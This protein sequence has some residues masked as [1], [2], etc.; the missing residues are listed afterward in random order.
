MNRPIRILFWVIAVIGVLIVFG[1]VLPSLVS[2]LLAILLLFAIADLSAR[3]YRN[4]VRTFNSAVRAVCQHEGAIA[5]VALAFSRSG[6]LSG[7]CYEYARR[8]MTGEDPVEAAGRARVP[9]QL[10]TAVALQ[11]PRSESAK[12][13]THHSDFDLWSS[14]GVMP[15]YGQFVYLTV[16]AMMT[17]VMLG[18][19]RVFILPTF[20]AMFEEFFSNRMPYRPLFSLIPAVSILCLIAFVIVFLL[21]LLNRG[22]LF[23]LRLPRWVPSLPRQAERRSETLHGLADAIEAGWSMTRAL[24]VARTVAIDNTQRAFLE[25]AIRKIHRGVDPVYAVHEAGWID[26]E[27]VVW[28]KDATPERKVGLLR[29]IADQDVRDARANL[30]WM[31]AVF[32][33]CLIVLMG[34]AV[35]AFTYGV[36]GILM[37]IVDGLA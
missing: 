31:M 35:M 20:E 27:D 4:S 18:F 28:L 17:C 3:R 9:L 10:Q 30:R 1:L 2:C 21:P 36:F 37:R 14:E 11:S 24:E 19:M 33:P 7:P 15:A 5:K 6:S 13:K 32:F 26:K 8:L 12:I 34:A 22:H 23:G 16:T 29:T 25:Q